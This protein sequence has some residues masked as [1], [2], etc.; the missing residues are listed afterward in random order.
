MIGAEFS[1]CGEAEGGEEGVGGE[2]EAGQ[3]GQVEG[4]EHGE[5]AALVHRLHHPQQEG[6]QHLQGSHTESWHIKHRGPGGLG[7]LVGQSRILFL[8]H[9]FM[10]TLLFLHLS[11]IILSPLS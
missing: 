5:V 9:P 2:H 8:F 11:F 7:P 10:S 6:L 3:D 1:C 4:H